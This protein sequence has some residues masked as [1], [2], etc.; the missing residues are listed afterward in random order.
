MLQQ[1]VGAAIA[2]AVA[3]LG[4]LI[5]YF[6]FSRRDEVRDRQ[7]KALEEEV[8]ELKETRL[9]KIEAELERNSEKRGA[10]YTR[11]EE[12]LVSRRECLKQHEETERMFDQ[13]QKRFDGLQLGVGESNATVAKIEGIVN[14]IAE[15]LNIKLDGH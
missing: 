12:Q 5:F 11:M 6:L 3:L 13:L 7:L 4:Q 9:T 8:H 2:T 1:L 10:M 15:H 14:L